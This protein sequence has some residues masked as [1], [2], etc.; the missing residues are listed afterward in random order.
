VRQQTGGESACEP[1]PGSCGYSGE[2]RLVENCGSQRE[3][4]QGDDQ[5]QCKAGMVP[6]RSAGA[7]RP[8]GGAW[9]RRSGMARIVP[10]G[11]RPCKRRC[12]RACT[13]KCA[14]AFVSPDEL[15]RAEGARPCSASPT[16]TPDRHHDH[17]W[18]KPEPR[19]RRRRRPRM[20]PSCRPHHPT[21]PE[22]ATELRPQHPI[23]QRNG[24]PRTA[25]PCRKPEPSPGQP[26]TPG[27][28]GSPYREP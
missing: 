7:V 24:A 14:C 28:A 22:R 5:S 12:T 17:L 20:R 8:T 26:A 18:R 11:R 16:A 9:V 27:N 10:T 25:S 23:A 3:G 4:Q 1:D 2:V 21:V 19:E 15:E 13:C 6:V